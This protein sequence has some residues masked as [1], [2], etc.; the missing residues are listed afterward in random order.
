MTNT[1][2]L[3]NIVEQQTNAILEERDKAQEHLLHLYNERTQSFDIINT[4]TGEVTR[5]NEKVPRASHSFNWI[6]ADYICSL[7]RAGNTLKR[8][9]TMPDMPSMSVISVW[10]TMHPLFA[11]R[12]EQA[13]RDR[14][15]N[16]HDMALD[17]AMSVDN[18]D[19]VGIAKL[20]VD[21]LK[22]AAEKG[23]PQRYSAK[24]ENVEKGGITVIIETGV[25]TN[26]SQV[27][28]T[29]AIEVDS[30]GE[31]KGTEPRTNVHAETI[32]IQ[33][34][35]SNGQGDDNIGRISAFTGSEI[36]GGGPDDPYTPTRPEQSGASGGDGSTYTIEPLDTSGAVANGTG[37][38]EPR[39]RGSYNPN[40]YWQKQKG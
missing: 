5:S 40:Q 3:S 34:D 27:W 16:F 22:W 20:K 1:K 7:I 6:T 23:N 8:I 2:Q 19:E 10:C 33:S 14:A 17:V 35:E 15:E 36:F 32:K 4:L 26:H 12:I 31:F 11:K 29:T 28:E 25:P 39:N 18:K 38:E 13:R 24:Q 37:T 21:T 30:N 9:A